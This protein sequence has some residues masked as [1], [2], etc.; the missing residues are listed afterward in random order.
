MGSFPLKPPT[1]NIAPPHYCIITMIGVNRLYDKA[2]RGYNGK[3]PNQSGVF[4]NGR[5]LQCQIIECHI[6]LYTVI[7][8][9]GK[10]VFQENLRANGFSQ[11]ATR[12]QLLTDFCSDFIRVTYSILE[13]LE[14]SIKISRAL[15]GQ[16][17]YVH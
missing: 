13:K 5:F 4:Q 9:L 12:S 2:G 1:K 15:A 6:F 8:I 17:N 16:K 7:L 11:I 14:R 10:C 3:N